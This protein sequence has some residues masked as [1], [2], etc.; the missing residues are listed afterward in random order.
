MVDRLIR[1]IAYSQGRQKDQRY[2]M[3]DP[4]VWKEKDKDSVTHIRHS[5]FEEEVSPPTV[6]YSK[7]SYSW[8]AKLVTLAEE[9]R[10]RL[11]NMDEYHSDS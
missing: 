3:V 8:K 9:M 6:F 11:Q 4:N 2:P 5:F 10:R 7:A 1:F